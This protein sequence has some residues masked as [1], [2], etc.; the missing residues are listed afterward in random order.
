LVI[1]HDHSA[2]DKGGVSVDVATPEVTAGVGEVGVMVA[3][4]G[5][6]ISMGICT[7]MS[8]REI[9]S[10]KGVGKA[11]SVS[12][13]EAVKGAVRGGTARG[14]TRGTDAMGTLSS[15]S[16]EDTSSR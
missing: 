3:G 13:V 4:L 7:I 9:P 6:D 16:S 15:S 8:G 11:T 5:V 14:P 2:A 10:G 1:R 12:I